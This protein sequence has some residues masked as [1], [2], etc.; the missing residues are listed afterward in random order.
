MTDLSHSVIHKVP[1]DFSHIIG[2]KVITITSFH[3]Y[4]IPVVLSLIIVCVDVQV[5][6]DLNIYTLQLHD[7]Y[8]CHNDTVLPLKFTYV[9]YQTAVLHSKGDQCCV[10]VECYRQKL[11]SSELCF[12]VWNLV[13]CY[14]RK[15]IDLFRQVATT[16]TKSLHFLLDGSSKFVCL[17]NHVW[18]DFKKRFWLSLGQGTRV[19]LARLTEIIT[20]ICVCTFRKRCNGQISAKHVWLWKIVYLTSLVR[21]MLLI[22]RPGGS[23]KTPPPFP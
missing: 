18:S 20:T 12:T 23:T 3:L 6:K 1:A 7:N 4:K 5:T 15:T 8:I 19:A 16:F 2:I 17:K 10:L 11:P 14:N 9:W 22:L 21:N 13:Y